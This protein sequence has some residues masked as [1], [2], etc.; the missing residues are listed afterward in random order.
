VWLAYRAGRPVDVPD[1]HADRDPDA[2]ADRHPVLPRAVSARV[3]FRILRRLHAADWPTPNPPPHRGSDAAAYGAHM[4]RYVD[5]HAEPDPCPDIGCAVA[6][7]Y[8]HCHINS[9]LLTDLD[10]AGPVTYGGRHPVLPDPDAHL[11]NVSA[12]TRREFR[13]LHTDAEYDAYFDGYRN[14]YADAVR[15]HVRGGLLV[16][17]DVLGAE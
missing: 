12:G 3:L 2:D 10:A 4:D 11:G 14:G 13:V 5:P 15:G 17:D 7:P 1:V 16:I 6:H 9:V 8:V